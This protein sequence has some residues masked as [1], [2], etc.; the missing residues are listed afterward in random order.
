MADQQAQLVFVYGSL[1]TGFNNYPV[2]IQPA[3]E[4]GK[5]S[6]VGAARTTN[7]EFHMVLNDQA[8]FPCLYRVPQGDGYK[9]SGDVFSLD[10]DTVAALD[11]FERVDD[12][13]YVRGVLD[14]DLVDGER[15]GETVACQVYFMSV[16]D[17]LA[18]LERITEYTRAMNAKF[19]QFM[20]DPPPD[21]VESI[22][23]KMPKQQQT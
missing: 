22:L 17:D 19:A 21:F 1:K 11:A 20:A 12:K 14:V 6:F 8:F 23:D 15:K 13:F 2:F 7:D 9:V 4:Q 18:R 3:I 10:R 5:A 16:Y